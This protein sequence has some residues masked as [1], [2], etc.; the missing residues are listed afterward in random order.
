MSWIALVS[1]VPWLQEKQQKRE[2][3]KKRKEKKAKN[4]RAKP[5]IA[6]RL[7]GSMVYLALELS[8]MGAKWHHQSRI[9]EIKHQDVFS[10]ERSSYAKTQSTCTED[11]GFFFLKKKKRNSLF[12]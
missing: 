3:R 10:E 8:N 11:I 2:K 9:G 5:T 6:G 4:L 1:F 12:R 7:H